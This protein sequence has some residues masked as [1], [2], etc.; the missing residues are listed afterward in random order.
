MWRRLP[1]APGRRNLSTALQ[2]LFESSLEEG[3]GCLHRGAFSQGKA[4]L[5][6]LL[7]DLEAAQRNAMPP[8]HHLRRNAHNALALCEQWTGERDEAHRQL[9][10]ALEASSAAA[11]HG[12]GH[13]AHIDV[14]GVLCDLATNALL[15][16]P[17]D[18]Q[19]ADEAE[20]F[21]KRAKYALSRAYRPSRLGLACV[22]SG[23]GALLQRRGSLDEALAMHMRAAS[24]TSQEASHAPFAVRMQL[25]AARAMLADGGL[26]AQARAAAAEALALQRD[27]E[28]RA[29][30][31]DLVA[32]HCEL[33]ATLADAQAPAVA[34]PE[35]VVARLRACASQFGA[36]LGVDHDHARC[37]R[38][39]TARLEDA[40][41]DA[42]H[43]VLAE[44][45]EPP[46][47]PEGLALLDLDAS[48]LTWTPQPP[49]GAAAARAA[50]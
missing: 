34:A 39:L 6:A 24:F 49:A 17:D 19:G 23:L 12:Q 43:G 40:D 29:G 50:A 15:L 22:H 38:A 45:R 21:L 46:L 5:A 26:A 41:A 20:R 42:W 31:S 30:A 28:E 25:G 16:H 27:A 2:T 37:V 36:T 11:C 9:R 3:I 35:E 13:D 1:I 44:V 4:T 48:Q 47:A 7:H 33:T 10:L 32:A 8:Q 14:A 18:E